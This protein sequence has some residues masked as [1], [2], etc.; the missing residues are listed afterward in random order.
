MGRLGVPDQNQHQQHQREAPQCRHP[1]TSI[2][3][4]TTTTRMTHSP[5][6]DTATS[7]HCQALPLLPQAPRWPI[8][9]HHLGVRPGP[10][11]APAP[12]C[13]RARICPSQTMT[14]TSTTTK[15]MSHQCQTMPHLQVRQDLVP[16]RL[17]HGPADE[18]GAV[19]LDE[20]DG[21]ATQQQADRDG[22]SSVPHGVARGLHQRHAASCAAQHAE[23]WLREGL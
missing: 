14:T 22:A 1:T 3:V 23:E 6:Q 10:T 15:P 4:L 13:R 21:H 2:T 9:S 7:R 19:T 20:R 16:L 17:R 8:I 12:T 5:L 11:M 18:E